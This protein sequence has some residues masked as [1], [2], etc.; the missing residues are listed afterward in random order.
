MDAN[1]QLEIPGKRSRPVDLVNF[2]LRR[3][4]WIV[5]LGF[6]IFLLLS[7][8]AFLL[9]KPYYRTSGRLLLTQ[10]VKM[11]LDR[12]EQMIHGDFRDFA[13]TYG[14]RL[15]GQAVTRKALS[16]LPRSQWPDFVRDIRDEE[17]AA[18]VLSKRIAVIPV[19]RSYLME[20]AMTSGSSQ[21]MAETLNAVMHSFLQLLEEEQAQD[22]DRRLAYL[23][24]ELGQ[25]RESLVQRE[26]E[27]RKVG[28]ELGHAS[29][30]AER[31]P[32]YDLLIAVQSDH[33][34]AKTAA[35]ERETL[36]A[37]ARRDQ[38]ILGKQD[39]TVFADEAVAS[40][41]AV[42]MIDNW[43]YQKL[44]DL[45][46]GI[47]GLTE[48]NDERIYVE[49]RMEAM[50]DYLEKFKRDLHVSALTIIEK[51]RAHE[52][53][54]AVTKA[55]SAA[56]ASADFEAN[57]RAQLDETRRAFARSSI[58][59]NRGKELNEE[60]V[61]IKGRISKVQDR[62]REVQLEAKLPVH[63][64]VDQLANPPGAPE[65]D[66]FGKLIV[67][68]FAGALGFVSMVFVVVELMD[69]RIRSSGDVRAALGALPADPIPAFQAARD[70]GDFAYCVLER[71]SHPVS[72]AIRALALRLERER[73]RSS[74][75]VFLVFGAEGGAGVS[76][77][78]RN[79]ADALTQYVERV[80]VLRLSEEEAIG[81]AP[82]GFQGFSFDC[83]F[84]EAWSKMSSNPDS[85]TCL[86]VGAET[87]L[88]RRRDW[89]REFIT[90]IS[91][92][93]DLILIDARPLKESDLT[94]YLAGCAQV[95]VVIAREGVTH[96]GPFRKSIEMLVRLR[97]PAIT[98]VLVGRTVQ[99]WDRVSG[100]GRGLIE[101]HL[102]DA[103]RAGL[104][105]FGVG[106]GAVRTW[107]YRIVL[108]R[109][110]REG[111]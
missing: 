54:E 26:G 80:L 50:N 56:Q 5:V 73:A 72:M 107:I 37:R 100:L 49:Q 1:L 76:W 2:A 98:A 42:F 30:S 13:A 82:G 24:K 77:L 84:Q 27:R 38:E 25:L 90:R 10:K 60:M 14:E 74:A 53:A 101:R 95:A 59:V 62:I 34:R 109:Q 78:G 83:Y 75:K 51:K 58:L 23:D 102:P 87:P 44:Q 81:V 32:F 55:Q 16:G 33:E 92:A 4:P 57:L 94:V 20:V 110:V 111:R 70:G 7:P 104:N 46:A 63:V 11:F 85:V 93:Y 88:M 79:V 52:L 18:R 91:P 43:T 99:P 71:P 29:F 40:N 48:S 3:G 9:S 6:G 64:G 19:G 106:L 47:D 45:R 108:R 17:I 96:F 12:Q 97:V 69:T 39:V 41:Q 89:L 21:G 8:A 36:L 15:V 103:V 65:G 66:N 68:L 61:E 28:E 105:V 67:M 31:N 86:H 22:C 35:L